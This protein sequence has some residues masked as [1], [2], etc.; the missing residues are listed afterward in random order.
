MRVK[1]LVSDRA[2]ALVKLGKP[3][4]LDVASM[5][6]LFH[7]AQDMAKAAGMKIG[8]SLS[9]IQKQLKKEGLKEG[10]K[11]LLGEKMNTLLASHNKYRQ[12]I[13]TINKTVH[14]FD[15]DNQL[16]G[17]GEIE[18]ELTKS[19]VRIGHIAGEL[20]IDI[21]TQRSS[22]IL[23]QIPDI[24]AGVQGWQNWL[25]ESMEKLLINEGGQIKEQLRTWIVGCLM[26]LAY[27]Q[28]N[29]PK[30]QSRKKNKDLRKYYAHRVEQAK[31]VYVENDLSKS[32]SAKQ[33]EE[34][35]AWAMDMARKFQRSSSRV[36]GRNGYL[37]F[38]HHAHKGIPPKRL[39]V[40]TVVHNHDIR[41]ADGQSSADRLFKRKFPDLFEF[42]L[43][44][45]T[46]FP[47]PRGLVLTR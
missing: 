8:S 7:F 14:P 46:R 13:E 44:N 16:Q 1:G 3:D 24:A 42:V 18:K 22:K 23:H 35:M 19:F 28:I 9:R 26:P 37:A 2:V 45:V 25:K 31:T 33:E 10:E 32:L 20:A 17:A 39:E 34:Y 30:T 15:K 41:G 5:A 47:E 36:E 11:V 4:Y 38:V 27:W 29:L 12:E 43:Q 21:S 40:L 6:D